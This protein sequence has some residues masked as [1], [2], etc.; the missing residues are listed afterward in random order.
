MSE[1]CTDERSST[2]YELR[3]KNAFLKSWIINLLEIVLILWQNKKGIKKTIRKL[4][5][6]NWLA[7]CNSFGGSLRSLNIRRWKSIGYRLISFYPVGFA[8]SVNEHTKLSMEGYLNNLE[9]LK[10]INIKIREAFWFQHKTFCKTQVR[11]K[12]YICYFK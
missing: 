10:S 1:I 3:S 12:K 8:A 4:T 9:A 11:I 7:H 6:L 2:L 5:K